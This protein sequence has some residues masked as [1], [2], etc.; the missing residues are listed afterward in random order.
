MHPL[1]KAIV[2]TL[3]GLV[4]AHSLADTPPPAKPVASIE[5]LDVARYMG[6]WYEISRYPT[7]FQKKC[8]DSSRAEYAL[9]DNGD[10]IVSSLQSSAQ[11]REY[12]D[13]DGIPGLLQPGYLA[14]TGG[15]A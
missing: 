8:R 3:L 14:P 9:K 7:W 15:Q 10:T 6:R 5:S 1:H 12:A 4:A 11:I 13:D 2:S